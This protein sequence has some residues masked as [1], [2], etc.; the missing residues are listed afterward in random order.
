MLLQM[1]CRNLLGRIAGVSQSRPAL[2]VISREFGRM[3]DWL[4]TR[5]GKELVGNDAHRVAPKRWS[6]FGARRREVGKP[7]PVY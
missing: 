5:E 6:T 4:R 2:S 7:G 1:R 3:V